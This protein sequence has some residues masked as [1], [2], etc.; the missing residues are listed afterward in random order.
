M[1][2]A[3]VVISA[4]IEGLAGTPR[5]ITIIVSS[6]FAVVI[7]LWI[8]ISRL[9]WPDRT[10]WRADL[11]NSTDYLEGKEATKWRTHRQQ[12]TGDTFVLDI[13]KSPNKIIYYILKA[14]SKV[15]KKIRYWDYGKARVIDKVVFMHGKDSPDYPK[16]W[17]VILNGASGILKEWEQ[18]CSGLRHNISFTIDTPE[19]VYLIVVEIIEPRPNYH[20]S[21]SD[22]KIREVRLF[23]KYWRMNIK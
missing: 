3:G 13:R 12:E 2:V 5:M 16:K 8:F 9:L 1:C 10:H 23:G 15:F 18:E 17:R 14:T 20:W 4:L 19:P 22:I 21:V 7:G 6:S 11:L